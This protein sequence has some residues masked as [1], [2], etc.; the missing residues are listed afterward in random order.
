MFQTNGSY[1]NDNK[2]KPEKTKKNSNRKQRE[3]KTSLKKQNVM[4]NEF[5]LTSAKSNFPCFF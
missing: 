1:A 3:S 5:L 2:M 4:F